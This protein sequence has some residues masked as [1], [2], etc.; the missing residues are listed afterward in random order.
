M[1]ETAVALLLHYKYW[2]LFPLACFEGPLI[3]VVVGFLVSLGYF[4][5]LAAY[6]IFILGDVIPDGIYYYIGRYGKRAELVDR[7]GT[8]IGLGPKRVD[9]IARL[10]AEHP[11]KMMWVTKFA[12]GLSTPL[13]IFAGLVHV[14]AKTFFR[15]SVPYS[16]LQY[17]VLMTLGYFFGSS[18]ILISGVFNGLGIA[19]T[20]VVIV[21]GAYIA[22]TKYIRKQFWVEEQKEEAEVQAEVATE[23]R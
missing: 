20:A 22:F 23:E 11:G 9:A 15:Y 18:Y 14:P 12:Y 3:S 16:L 21:G 1:P 5:P 6:A 8:K 2:I 10:W 17:A 4:N 13:L 7:W 19:V